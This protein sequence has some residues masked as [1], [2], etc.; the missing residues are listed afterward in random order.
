MIERTCQQCGKQFLVKPSV[1]NHG[2]GKFCSIKCHNRSQV[3]KQRPETIEKMA[4]MHRGKQLTAEHRQKISETNKGHICSPKTREKISIAL[5]GK[6][7]SEEHKAKIKA[8]TPTMLGKHHSAIAREKVSKARK[9]KSP[10]FVHRRKLSVSLK[11]LWLDPEFAKRMIVAFHKKPTK[12]EIQLEAILNKHFLQYKYNGDG[13]LG[14]MIGGFIP[15]FPNINGKKD[16]IEVF[17]DYYHSTDVLGDR[18]N[19]S[20][21]GK[22]MVYNSLGYRCLVIWEHELNEL[23]EEE[24]VAKIKNFQRRK[25]AHATHP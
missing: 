12:P 7:K 16:L 23:S 13:R 2:G 3:G 9:G 11:R 19:G 20:E 22:I 10:S 4:A 18:W 15:D 14:V 8:R 6:P 24:I 5:T 25:H 21:L 17:G 1:I